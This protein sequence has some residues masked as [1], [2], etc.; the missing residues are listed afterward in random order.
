MQ[1]NQSSTAL[2]RSD[3]ALEE[4]GQEHGDDG[5]VNAMVR[6]LWGLPGWLVWLLVHLVFLTGFKSRIGA[7]FSR[8]IRLLRPVA[9]RAHDHAAAGRRPPR[10]RGR[11]RSL[12]VAAWTLTRRPRG[13]EDRAAPPDEGQPP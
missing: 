11:S 12:S 7:L 4:A 3:R 5:V 8:S 2:V 13:A 9:L 10:P 1:S 6:H